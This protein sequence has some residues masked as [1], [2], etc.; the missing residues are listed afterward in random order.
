M[1]EPVAAALVSVVVCAAIS[2]LT[3][4]SVFYDPATGSLKNFGTSQDETLFPA[5]MAMMLAGYFVYMLA[6][7]SQA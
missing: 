7:A 6:F 2:G 3:K 1:P 4:W 5:W